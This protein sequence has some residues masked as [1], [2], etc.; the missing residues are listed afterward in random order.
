MR[1][2]RRFS[3]R[4]EPTALVARDV[5]SIPAVA[6]RESTHFESVAALLADREISGMPVVDADD[7]V[8]G[9]ISERDLAHALGGP[10]IRLAIRKPVGSGP[11]LRN[12]RGA[13]EGAY[14][15]K[16][17]MTVPPVTVDPDSPLHTL[18]EIMVTDQVNRLPVVRDERLVGVVTRGD[19]LAALAGLRERRPVALDEAPIVVGDG[20]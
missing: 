7:R 8:V 3:M 18:A 15:A 11:F 6:C 5:M 10:L 1:A 17:I 19:V 16:D 9:V 14:R 13:A 12:P 2:Q 20:I 4:S